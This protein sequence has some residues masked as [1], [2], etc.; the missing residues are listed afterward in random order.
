MPRNLH[1]DPVLDDLMGFLQLLKHA[2]IAAAVRGE[3]DL[4]KLLCDELASRGIDERG[5]WIGFPKARALAERLTD[6]GNAFERIAS[7]ELGIKTLETR[8]SDSLDFYDVAVWSVKNALQRAAN[9]GGTMLQKAGAVSVPRAI[10][11][12]PILAGDAGS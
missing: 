6:I 8:R 12:V 10:S 7:E 5:Q 3:V 4:R 1:D 2:T 11:E 9:I